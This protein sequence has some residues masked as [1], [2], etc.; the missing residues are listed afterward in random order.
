VYEV[1]PAQ[2]ATL[3]RRFQCSVASSY[4]IRYLFSGKRPAEGATFS[5]S[6][7]VQIKH[8]PP[9]RTATAISTGL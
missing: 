3:A 9:P 7:L 1:T 8:A 2:P 6:A 4:Q 5:K